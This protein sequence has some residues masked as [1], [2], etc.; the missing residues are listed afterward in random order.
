M[1]FL[2]GVWGPWGDYSSCSKTCRRG[3]Q[4]RYRACIGGHNCDG[5]FED[6]KYC[7]EKTPCRNSYGKIN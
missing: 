6:I 2:D 4:V 7:N 5:E 3:L 1:K